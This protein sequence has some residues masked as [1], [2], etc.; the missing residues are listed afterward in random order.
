MKKILLFTITIILTLCSLVFSQEIQKEYYENGNLQY[1]RTF[2]D[3]QKDGIAKEYFKNGN[4]KVEVMYDQGEMQGEFKEYYPSGALKNVRIY[5][6]G[7]IEG[8]TKKYNEDGKLTAELTRDRGEM[9]W[10]L[11]KRY[12]YYPTGDLKYKYMYNQKTRE[13]YRKNF[14]ENGQMS[15]E[16]NIIDGQ[17]LDCKNYNKEGVFLSAECPEK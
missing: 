2:K 4:V 8:V 17:F 6:D 5:V 12:D 16:F 14:H 7:V 10:W 11:T 13:G 9:S 3:R 1:E 15:T